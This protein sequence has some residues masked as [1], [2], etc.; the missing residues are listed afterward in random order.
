MTKAEGVS[1]QRAVQANALDKAAPS[2]SAMLGR[3]VYPR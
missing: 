3:L 2:P 1:P